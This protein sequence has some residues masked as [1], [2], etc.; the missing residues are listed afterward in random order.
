[1]KRYV[2][3]DYGVKEKCKELQTKEFQAVLDLCLEGGG[4]VVVPRGEFHV[5]ALYLH[6]NTTLRLERGA[7]VVLVAPAASLS[8]KP[9]G[10]DGRENVAVRADGRIVRVRREH[11]HLVG[12]VQR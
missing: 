3:T 5:G 2:I 8:Y 11:P 12:H 7:Q 9:V 4:E 10:R 6:S 1:M